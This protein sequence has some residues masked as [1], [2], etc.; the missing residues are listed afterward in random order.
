M[1]V[2]KK[3]RYLIFGDVNISC[4]NEDVLKLA[5]IKTKENMGSQT[6]Q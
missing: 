1:L 4:E 2:S 3:Y 6:E 5:D